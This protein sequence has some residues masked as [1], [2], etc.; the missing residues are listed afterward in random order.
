MTLGMFALAVPGSANFA[1]EFA[2]LAGRLRPRLG[3]RGGRRRGDRPRGAVRAAP[4]LRDP[5]RAARERRARGRRRPR[6]RRARARR[7]ARRDPRRPLRLAGRDQ[8]AL[9][10]RRRADGDH[11]AQAADDRRRDRHAEGRLA[12]ALARA[13]AARRVR[14]SRCSARCSC[15]RAR[16]AAFSALVVARRLRRPPAVLAA[17]VFDRS[18]EAQLAHRRVDDPRPA[19]RARAD[20]ARRDRG[21]ASCSSRSATGGATTSASTTRSSRR[22]A[23]GCCSSSPPRT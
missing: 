14:R 15:P 19:R 6:R 20:R 5:P 10:P 11:R 23:P 4:D 1:G 7:A 3:L 16:G 12:R 22:P 18:P 2:I 13:G 17:V 8:R 21:R 9:V